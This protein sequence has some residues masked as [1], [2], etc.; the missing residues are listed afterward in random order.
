MRARA[1]F[2]QWFAASVLAVGGAALAAF[3]WPQMGRSDKLLESGVLTEA[4]VVALDPDRCSYSNQRTNAGYPCFRA[5]VAWSHE[6]VAY[7]TTLGF[8]KHAKE[9][10]IGTRVRIIFE[11]DPA[12]AAGA[13]DLQMRHVPAGRTLPP[14]ERP[15]YLGLLALAGLLCLPLATTLLR[16]LRG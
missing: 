11:P 2:A 13:V 4:T 9:S 8:Y 15:V 1:T 14:S 10:P 5:T 6:G 16:L 12:A 7:R 3:V